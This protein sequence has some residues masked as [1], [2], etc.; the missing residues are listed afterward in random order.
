M[1]GRKILYFFSQI[2]KS[3]FLFI[4]R[5]NFCVGTPGDAKTMRRQLRSS[6]AIKWI[7]NYAPAPSD[8]FWENLSITRPCWY[9]NAFLI[10]IALGLLLFFITTPVVSIIAFSFYLFLFSLITNNENVFDN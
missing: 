10:N 7:V 2:L 6:P 5:H 4:Y 8:I 1:N 9:L 3:Y